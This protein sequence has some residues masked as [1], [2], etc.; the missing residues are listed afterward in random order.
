MTNSPMRF[1]QACVLSVA[2]LV[3]LTSYVSAGE[4]AAQPNK[5]T[6]VDAVVRGTG[7]MPWQ[8][9]EVSEA[10]QAFR[11]EIEA[12]KDT[13]LDSRDTPSH[14]RILS[15]ADLT[16]ARANIKNSGWAKQWFDARKA[17]ADYLVAQPPEYVESMLS[18]LT[19]ANPYGTT[20]PN[21]VG[22]KSQEG[23]G[24]GIMNWNHREP[25]IL[26]CTKCGQVYPDPGFPE[27]AVLQ[28]PRMGQE[29]TYYLNAAERA[30]PDDRSGKLAYHWVGKPLHMSFSGLIRYHKAGFMRDGAL[31]LAYAYALTGNAVYAVRARDILVRFAHCYRNWLY[32]DYWDTIADCDPMYAA[33]HDK[34]L[35]LEWKKHLATGAFA[36]DSL[37]KA[38]MLQSYWGGGR[39]HPST[40]TVGG[41][42]DLALAYDLVADAKD[43]EGKPV[44]SPAERDIVERD[45]LLEWIMGAEPYVGGVGKADIV[46]RL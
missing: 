14:P 5:D 7:L 37:E 34:S 10:E 19:P 35:P 13:L 4:T 18:E 28:A 23:A 33:W 6:Y 29:F 43:V 12:R 38:G 9:G 8:S 39:Y 30:N 1:L 31:D 26:R 2:M 21:C 15:E 40:D 45:L 24:H 36:G 17:R 22:K 20:C 25:D 16:R 3:S 44:W 27:T 11:A 42:A 41:V 32:H 46:G